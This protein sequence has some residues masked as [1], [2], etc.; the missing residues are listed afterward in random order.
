[1]KKLLY[2]PG[3]GAGWST[4]NGGEVA[5]F[6]V[7]YQPIINAIE[8]GEDVCESHP[9]VAQMVD[10]IEKKFGKDYVCVLGANNLTVLT[11]DD[12]VD[13]SFDEYDGNESPR[14]RD[15]GLWF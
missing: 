1:M 15:D 11:V 13:V 8:N 9:A 10:E 3:F 4:W 2:S 12:D 7:T 5:K 6:M 14:Y